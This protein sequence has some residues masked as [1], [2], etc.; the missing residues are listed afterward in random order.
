M[1][2]LFRR[3]GGAI[4]VAA[5]GLSIAGW[6]TVASLAYLLWNLF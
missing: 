2:E 3:R 1:N 5:V 6:A 4:V